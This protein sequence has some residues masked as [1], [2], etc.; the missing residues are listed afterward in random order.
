MTKHFVL[1]LKVFSK[2][3]VVQVALAFAV[4]DTFPI[5]PHLPGHCVHGHGLGKRLKAHG[6]KMIGDR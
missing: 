3:I 6:E 4:V 2:E 5:V 1:R